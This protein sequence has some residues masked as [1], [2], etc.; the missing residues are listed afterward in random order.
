[1]SQARERGLLALAHSWLHL[2]AGLEQVGGRGFLVTS[3][4]DSPISRVR[5]ETGAVQKDELP[6]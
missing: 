5:P 6:G 2:R 1:M 3:H 4:P